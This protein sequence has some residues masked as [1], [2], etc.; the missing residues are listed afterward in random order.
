MDSTGALGVH[1]GSASVTASTAA[2]ARP[3]TNDGSRTTF[4][5][6]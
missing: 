1:P 3:S 2:A 6:T 5:V 4:R